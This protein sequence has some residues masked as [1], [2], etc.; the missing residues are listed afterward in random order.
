MGVASFIQL[1]LFIPIPLYDGLG[2]MLRSLEVILKILVFTKYMSLLQLRYALQ[3][4]FH[5]KGVGAWLNWQLTC[6]ASAR[7]RVQP[8]YHKKHH[9]TPQFYSFTCLKVRLQILPP[10]QKISI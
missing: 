1:F 8:Q 3:K 4:S 10:P 7:A 2:Y 5:S 6:L 9:S